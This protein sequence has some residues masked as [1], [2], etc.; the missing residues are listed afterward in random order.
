MNVTVKLF[1]SL[2]TNRFSVREW[3]C[4]TDQSVGDVLVDLG[5]PE[6]DAALI[7]INGRHAEPSSVLREG[8]VLALFPPV[9]GG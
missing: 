1:A 7:F 2:R 8:D 5:I 9:G 3:R 4:E 6:E